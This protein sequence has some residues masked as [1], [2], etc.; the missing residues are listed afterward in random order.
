[1]PRGAPPSPPWSRVPKSAYADPANYER[2]RLYR[3]S[4][5][6]EILSRRQYD[7]YYGRLRESPLSQDAIHKLNKART[8]IKD[9][10]YFPASKNYARLRDTLRELLRR[11]YREVR[12]IYGPKDGTHVNT[13]WYTLSEGNLPYIM[14]EVLLSWSNVYPDGTLAEGEVPVTYSYSDIYLIAA[15]K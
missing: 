9:T 1:M 12:F 3:N 10:D 6:G 2:Q 15:I 7:K 4:Q 13:G 11:G 5:T 14:G 8:S